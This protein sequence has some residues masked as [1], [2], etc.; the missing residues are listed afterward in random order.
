MV[1]NKLAGESLQSSFLRNDDS[2]PLEPESQ[3]RGI[4]NLNMIGG[5]NNAQ[6]E[7]ATG[8]SGGKSLS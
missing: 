7:E 6:G 4:Q 8:F 1:S 2:L 3:R 5:S